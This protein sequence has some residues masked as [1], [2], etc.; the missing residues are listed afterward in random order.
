MVENVQEFCDGEWEKSGP[1]AGEFSRPVWEMTRR[2]NT[3]PASSW[4]ASAKWCPRARKTLLNNWGSRGL[5]VSACMRPVRKWNERVHVW[6]PWVPLP[7]AW[8][9]GEAHWMRSEKHY[10]QRRGALAKSG[11]GSEARIDPQR[12]LT[13]RG[14]SSFLYPNHLKD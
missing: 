10:A 1:D 7:P 14:R 6:Q 4:Q 9:R 12:W 3:N 13:N 11:R 5:G 8:Q 2:Q